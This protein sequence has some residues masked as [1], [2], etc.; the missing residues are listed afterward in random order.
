MMEKQAE[1][2]SL[3]HQRKNEE[4]T[5]KKRSLSDQS[6]AIHKQVHFGGKIQA[7]HTS[8]RSI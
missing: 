7:S 3:S 8:L 1:I 6:N 4:K 2:V 5:R